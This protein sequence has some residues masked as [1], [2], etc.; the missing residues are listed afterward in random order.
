MPVMHGTFYCLSGQHAAA[1]A[2]VYRSG[3]VTGQLHKVSHNEESP[4][5]DG[6]VDNHVFGGE[7]TA[8]IIN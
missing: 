1:S 8:I 3:Q 7:G 5:R 2:V 6:V 4:F